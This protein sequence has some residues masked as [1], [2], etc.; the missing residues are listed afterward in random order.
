[1]VGLFG[2]RLLEGIQEDVWLL[3]QSSTQR[4]HACAL[5]HF[6]DG[7]CESDAAH[8]STEHSVTKDVLNKG[9]IVWDAHVALIIG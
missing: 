7:A 3:Q 2:Q 4:M 8:E 1:M 5:R 9:H 6:I